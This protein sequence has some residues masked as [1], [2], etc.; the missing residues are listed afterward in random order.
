MEAERIVMYD[1]S[2]TKVMRTIAV[3]NST[4]YSTKYAA[5]PGKFDEYSPIAQTMFDSFTPSSTVENYHY[6]SYFDLV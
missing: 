6:P 2:T 1:G 5:E 4:A 3:A